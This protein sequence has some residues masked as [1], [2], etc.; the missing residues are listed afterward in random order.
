MSEY[1]E[2]ESESTENP[3]R[4]II[5]TN[6]NLAEDGPETYPSISNMEVGSPLAQMLSVIDGLYSLVID[7]SDII[8]TCDPDV[9]QHILI[10]DITDVVKEFFL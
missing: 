8:V 7:G 2:I 5:H 1:I 3:G 6:L 9:P 10:A 4:Y